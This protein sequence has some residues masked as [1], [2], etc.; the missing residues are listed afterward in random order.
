MATEKC[1]A[2]L[3][4]DSRFKSDL[5][6]TSQA[7][8]GLKGNDLSDAE[9]WLLSQNRTSTGLEWFLQIESPEATS[10]TI[11]YSNS[12]TLSINED[13]KINSL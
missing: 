9:S 2:Q 4:S 8:L 1:K 6:Y 7:V 3:I 11:T 5:K 13:K 12:N 10:C